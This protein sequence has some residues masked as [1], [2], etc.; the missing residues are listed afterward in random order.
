MPEETNS[1]FNPPPPKGRFALTIRCSAETGTC[2]RICAHVLRGEPVISPARRR[3]FAWFERVLGLRGQST[4]PRVETPVKRGP[5]RP[6]GEA[7]E[8]QAGLDMLTA[9]LESTAP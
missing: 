3:A 1:P 8:L 7:H 5:G 2:T 6:K 4:A 9:A